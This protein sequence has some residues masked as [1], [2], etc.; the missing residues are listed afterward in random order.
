MDGNEAVMTMKRDAMGRVKVPKARR[1]ALVDEFERSALPATQFARAAGVNY[2]TFA[3][4]VQQR[5]H[6]RGDYAQ[7]KPARSSAL[8]LVEAVV[9]APAEGRADEGPLPGKLQSDTRLEV[10]LPGGAKLIVTDA[11]QVPLAVQLLNALRVPCW[12]FPAV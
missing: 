5:R 12:A 10:L 4:W 1:E 11:A 3:C 8:R 7:M 6:A 2:Q 9:A